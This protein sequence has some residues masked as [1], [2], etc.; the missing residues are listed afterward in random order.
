RACAAS[1]ASST[2]RSSTHPRPTSPSTRRSSTTTGRAGTRRSP[3]SCGTTWR[4]TPPSSSACS[5]PTPPATSGTGRPSRADRS[6][7]LLQ[8]RD[9][10]LDGEPGACGDVLAV[11]RVQP[12]HEVR[13]PARLAVVDDGEERVGLAVV[14]DDA[15]ARVGVLGDRHV[16]PPR[17]A[18]GHR[19]VRAA[20]V[21]QPLERVTVE[22]GAQLAELADDRAT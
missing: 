22:E 13:G 6:W 8:L 18:E 2:P 12:R 15:R 10:A 5:P 14:A 17:L 11:R 19:E 21:G 20:A 3:S 9:D 16:R 1:S 7:D 4:S